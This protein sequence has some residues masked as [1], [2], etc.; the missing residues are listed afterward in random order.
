MTMNNYNDS[1]SKAL[2]KISSQVTHGPGSNPNTPVVHP[3]DCPLNK[4]RNGLNNTPILA[5]DREC[6]ETRIQMQLEC[7]KCKNRQKRANCQRLM[8]DAVSACKRA[9]KA[10]SE[11]ENACNPLPPTP[12]TFPP[13]RKE[14]P[15]GSI[16]KCQSA[17]CRFLGIRAA[18]MNGKGCL[19]NEEYNDVRR[20]LRDRERNDDD[21]C[22]RQLQQC[23]RVSMPVDPTIFSR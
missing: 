22:K 1:L 18:I 8:N 4:C 16:C 9:G 20:D 12:G 11:K 23:K 7:N 2:N 19:S 17:S 15:P 3:C 14:P 13:P 10:C 5:T 21:S 6:E